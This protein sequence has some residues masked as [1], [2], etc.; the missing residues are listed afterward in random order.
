MWRVRAMYCTR[1]KDGHVKPGVLISA[2]YVVLGLHRA[3]AS[4][5]TSATV[6]FC[7]FSAWA[8][9]NRLRLTAVQCDQ[10]LNF[11]TCCV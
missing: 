9:G 1:W 10:V 4:W 5:H 2:L 6:G 8:N 3:W 11:K 7:C